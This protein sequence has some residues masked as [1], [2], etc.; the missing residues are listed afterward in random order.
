[1]LIK[2]ERE[3]YFIEF[4]VD[5]ANNGG[6]LNFKLANN[7]V[8]DPNY[9]YDF[10]NNVTNSSKMKDYDLTN[11]KIVVKACLLHN[12]M[13]NYDRCPTG[14]ELSTLSYTNRYTNMAV[15]IPYPMMGKWFLAVWK[16]CYDLKTE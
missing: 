3:P 16:E 6:T 9:R 14:Y 2:T 5:L 10:M 8:L 12:S 15:S 4:L 13:S 7:L 11:V 1:M